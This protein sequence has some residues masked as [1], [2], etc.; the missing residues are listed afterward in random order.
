MREI[1]FSYTN[2]GNANMTYRGGTP[3]TARNLKLNSGLYLTILLKKKKY[4]V[5]FSDN[6]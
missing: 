4:T 3:V 5:S 1:F 6:E 2:L